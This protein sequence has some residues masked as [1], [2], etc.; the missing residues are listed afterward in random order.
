MIDLLGPG[1]LGMHC[2]LSLPADC[3]LRLR[4]PQANGTAWTLSRDDGV[5]RT[6]P[7]L[8]L[9]DP[10][11]IG[12]L[13]VTT[14]AAQVLP[15]INAVLP[16]LTPTAEVLLLHNGF[17]P[18]DAV[19]E[20]LQ[21]TQKLY[22][23]VSTEGV[24]R[25]GARTVSHRSV[26][27]TQ[28]GPWLRPTPQPELYGVLAA[29]SWAMHW[30]ANPQQTQQWVW[31]KL[32]I[33]AAINPLTALLDVRNGALAEPAHQAQWQPVVQEACRIA[34]AQG[35]ALDMTTE[36]ARVMGV[37]QSTARNHS[38]MWQDWAQGRRSEADYIVLPLLNLATQ[39][40]LQ[41]PALEH[42][43]ASIQAHEEAGRLAMG[44]GTLT[45]RHHN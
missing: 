25:T 17:G 12:Q 45:S 30:S 5:A 43:Y 13:I 31:Q 3:A 33:N 7:S 11:P 19:A 34:S 6:L 37:I 32:I 20:L 36:C 40:E 14:K 23:G 28:V 21:P 22:V 15:A 35:L 4:H 16:W 26:G 1:A 38:S 41:C 39:H 42:L 9:T 18:Q 8:A 27:L 24:V 29:G 10:S 44:S 2:A